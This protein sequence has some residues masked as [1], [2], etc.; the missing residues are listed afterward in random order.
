M[1]DD[2][3]LKKPYGA[4]GKVYIMDYEPI[5][6]AKTVQ[7][8]YGEGTLYDTGIIG[9]ILPDGTIDFLENAGRTVLTDGIHGRKY[10]DL[11]ILEKYILE[12][13]GVKYVECYL[14]YD[15]EI[16]EMSLYADIK[17]DSAQIDIAG[18]KEFVRDKAGDDVFLK[19]VE[20]VQ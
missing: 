14:A 9:R 18:L 6:C 1:L 17:T 2:D 16:N 11:K 12:Y 7:Y 15:P 8:P 5:N 13:D 10:Y 4:W 19:N 3:Y 20:I